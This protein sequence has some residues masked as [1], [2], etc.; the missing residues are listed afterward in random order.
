[1]KRLQSS[2]RDRHWKVEMKKVKNIKWNAFV[3]ILFILILGLLLTGC[4][5]SGTAVEVTNTPEPSS[6]PDV[7]AGSIRGLVWEDLCENYDQGDSAPV[8]CVS[9]G[10]EMSYVANG[11]LDANEMGIPSERILL[12]RGVCPSEG[13]ASTETDTNGKFSFSGLDQGAYCVTVH[14]SGQMPG[15]WTYPQTDQ[16]MGVGY[17]TITIS[18]AETVENVNF[19]R[20]Y[21]YAPPTPV[22]T[23]APTPVACTD[24]AEFVRDVTIPDGARLDPG[25]TFSKTWRFLNSGTCTWTPEY[26]IVFVSGSS[27]SG[28][29]TIALPGQVSPGSQVDLSVLLQAPAS[30]GD[31]EGFW[32]LRNGKGNLFGIGDYGNSPFW[33]RIQV[34]PKPEPEITE[35]RGEYYDN[36]KLTGDYALVRN[37]KKIDFNWGNGSPDT[38]LSSDHFSARWTRKLSFDQAIYRFH[39]LMDDGAA[40]W[41]DDRLVI[42]EW[43]EGASREVT[44]DLEMSKGE[45]NIKVEYFEAGGQAKVSFWSEKLTNVSYKG[46]KGLYWFNKTLDSKWAL[47][48]DD[49]GINFDWKFGSPAMGI[50]E[51]IFSIRWQKE[52]DFDPGKYT[53]Y[54]YADDGFRFYL[55]DALIIDEWHISNGSELYSIEMEVTGKHDLTIQYYEQKQH[56]KVKFWWERQNE[57]PIALSDE[58]SVLMETELSVEAPGVLQNDS[59]GDGDALTVSLVTDAAHGNL[60][61]SSDGSFL[62]EPSAG[63]T[64]IDEFEYHASDGLD[65]SNISTVKI[66]VE[67]LNYVPES[68]DDTASTDQE[69]P[70]DIDVLE[71][72][73]GLGDTPLILTIEVAPENGSAEIVEGLIRYSPDEGFVGEDAFSYTVTDADGESSTAVVTITV[74][75]TIIEP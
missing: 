30:N 27:M 14:D 12:G 5:F 21:F 20:D 71:N 29:R 11:I 47:V 60:L 37:D 16:R 65:E 63:F 33:V 22:P 13:L 17:M 15:V 44:I 56:A 64:G 26:S 7:P 55:D 50:P 41:I 61:L 48:R 45:H 35:W 68:V 59:D 49:D 28:A 10:D 6:T 24:K 43:K 67:P 42:D 1:M 23:V 72:D 58:Y 32:K 4:N 2:I 18:D 9:S 25:M 75:P 69:T 39:L 57:A 62:Y 66:V 31:Y 8:G 70:L 3:T 34:G 46:W 73:T 40:L 54:A 36:L 19:G 38:A 53:F 74:T 51:D 52:V